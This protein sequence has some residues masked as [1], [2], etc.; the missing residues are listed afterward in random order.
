VLA[1]VSA[2]AAQDAQ[3][4]TPAAPP[5]GL[6]A[7]T[8]PAAAAPE[9]AATGLRVVLEITLRDTDW[10]RIVIELDEARAPRT[11][12]NFLRYVDEGFY[13]NTVFHRVI[14]NFVI[15]GGGYTTVNEA[16][17]IGLHEP[18]EN[19]SRNGLKN[20]R[21]TVAA[22]RVAAEPNSATSQFFIN[23]VDNDT[24]D[25]PADGDGLGFC[26]F[27]KVVEGMEV[28]DRIKGVATRRN[29]AR[30]EERSQPIHAPTIKRAY[31]ADRPPP[32]ATQPATAAAEGEKPPERPSI[33]ADN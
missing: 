28:V 17:S 31:R 19:E 33:E 8:Q 12:Q 20:L 6:P 14:T 26:V 3:P 22:A 2:A 1:S 23:V 25:P 13:N 24:L 11:V 4:P 5:A 10:G 29:P 9:S 30:P 21:S 15:Q 27:G 7:V 18:I 32:P 16:K